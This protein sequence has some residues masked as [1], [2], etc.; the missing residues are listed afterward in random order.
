MTNERNIKKFST[1]IPQIYD[2]GGSAMGN[3]FPDAVIEGYSRKSNVKSGML[4]PDNLL[5]LRPNMCS[6][7]WNI[8]KTI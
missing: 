7:L 1:V 2:V 8:Y 5:G 3:V 4:D 6:Y